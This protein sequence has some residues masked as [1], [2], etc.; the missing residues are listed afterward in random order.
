MGVA[1]ILHVIVFNKLLSLLSAIPYFSCTYILYAFIKVFLFY[2]TQHLFHMLCLEY[3]I[4]SRCNLPAYCTSLNFGLVLC[5]VR[6]RIIFI[7]FH[8]HIIKHT[9]PCF[10]IA[11]SNN[12]G[13]PSCQTLSSKHLCSWCIVFPG[14]LQLHA[15]ILASLSFLFICN[16]SYHLFQKLC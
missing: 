13:C 8:I 9:C 1:V 6:Y 16:R 12:A 5:H 15:I 11:H 10:S 7:C 4:F 3:W 2:F 14:S